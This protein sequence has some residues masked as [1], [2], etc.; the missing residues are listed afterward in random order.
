MTDVQKLADSGKVAV[1]TE[2][3]P[4]PWSL[5]S[6]WQFLRSL[7]YAVIAAILPL[8]GAAFLALKNGQPLVIPWNIMEGT[9]AYTA[10]AYLLA[11]LPQ[12]TQKIT[13]FKKP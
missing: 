4:G 2:V 3:T 10:V 11:K 9:A 5:P 12:S 6:I 8:L 13:T 1:S 7:L